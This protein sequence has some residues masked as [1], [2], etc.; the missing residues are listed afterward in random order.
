MEKFTL[1]WKDFQSSVAE[2]FRLLRH[3]KDY[4]GV[5]LVSD[6]QIQI[7]AHKLILSAC[8]SFFK[9][10]L[11][12]NS[13][14]H[15]LIYITSVSSAD[16]GCILDYI[17][18]GE[19]AIYQDQLDSFLDLAKKFK[20]EG[21]L[22]VSQDEEIH[23]KEKDV[24]EKEFISYTSTSLE[25]KTQEQ[26][27]EELVMNYDLYQS[28]G[29]P[30]KDRP[31]PRVIQSY[32]DMF[33]PDIKSKVKELITRLGPGQYNCRVCGKMGKQ[34]NMRVHAVTHIDGLTYFCKSCKYKTATLYNALRVHISRTHK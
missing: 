17:Y 16:L 25:N 1:M 11:K 14:A 7:S 15:P 24:L 13:H 23:L 33:Q 12:Q 8:S 22:L 9:T 3:E 2:S 20:V 27:K 32:S 21:L 34:A 19:V 18:N 6:D 5:T 29:P 28:L 30:Q 31:S 10:I 4:F 26:I